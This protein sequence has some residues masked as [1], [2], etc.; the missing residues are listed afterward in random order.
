M[1]KE[2]V[3]ELLLEESVEEGELVEVEAVMEVFVDN[4]N[5]EECCGTRVL[6]GSMTAPIIALSRPDTLSNPV[7]DK[8]TPWEVE[9]IKFIPGKDDNTWLAD[10]DTIKSVVS[11]E[12]IRR[13]WQTSGLEAHDLDPV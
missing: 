3:E 13:S 2:T 4:V 7:Q 12:T 11:E 9:N 10:E 6:D 5:E 8:S 1:R